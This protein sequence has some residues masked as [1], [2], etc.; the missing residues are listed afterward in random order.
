MLRVVIDTNV[1]VSGMLVQGSVPAEV[2]T[3]MLSGRC[4]WL[5]DGR[6][7]TEYRAVL[8]RSEFAFP[9]DDVEA[10]LDVIETCGQ[11]VVARPLPISLPDPAD[12]PFIEVAVSGGADALVTGN[13]KHFKVLA[14]KLD[15]AILNPREMVAVL[16]R[17]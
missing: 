1:V 12:L 2:L 5:V 8:A 14:R 7:I 15:L 6:I 11:W 10:I 9:A 16:A 13:T 4:T 17:T 3:Q